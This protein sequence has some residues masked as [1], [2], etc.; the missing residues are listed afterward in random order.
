MHPLLSLKAENEK[1]NTET[2]FLTGAFILLIHREGK[3][4]A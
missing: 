3:T 1:A 4:P 2:G